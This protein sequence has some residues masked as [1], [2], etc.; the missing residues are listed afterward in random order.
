ME[1]SEKL[2]VQTRLLQQQMALAIMEERQRL[3]RDL[4]DSLGQVLGYVVVQG[5]AVHE[6]LAQGQVEL[7]DAE[8]ARLITVAR[9]AHSDV[10]AHILGL[11][12]ASA[13]EGFFPALRRY[14]QQFDRIYGMHT[15]LVV[16]D[17]SLPSFEAPV[18]V[19]LLRIIQEA[20]ANVRR[21]SGSREVRVIFSI[22]PDGVRVVIEDDGCGFDVA[23]S[24]H[25]DDQ[26]L[27]L[28]VMRERAEGIGGSLELASEPGRGT[29]VIVRL[30][31]GKEASIGS[32]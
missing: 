14:L 7:A 2:R 9:D 3:A 30:P 26:S 25:L 24:T 15:D 8:L 28:R 22:E 29:R 27:G 12:A 17:E 4:H 6:L 10:R 13:I 11:K 23:R 31:L 32:R 18:G 1:V 19:Q 21:H 20:L 16:P 5:Q